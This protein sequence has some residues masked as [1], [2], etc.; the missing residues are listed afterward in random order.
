MNT[1]GNFMACL[2]LVYFNKKNKFQQQHDFIL[3]SMCCS[4]EIKVALY[5]GI[6]SFSVVFSLFQ[7]CI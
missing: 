7:P 6:F 5:P 3:Y 4:I 1:D 2:M